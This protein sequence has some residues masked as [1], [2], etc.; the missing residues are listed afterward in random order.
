MRRTTQAVR[1]LEAAGSNP[2]K[3]GKAPI[4]GMATSLPDRG[5]VGDILTMYQD[6]V[7]C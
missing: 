1:E 7:C 5:A 6:L 2:V 4:Y 3:G